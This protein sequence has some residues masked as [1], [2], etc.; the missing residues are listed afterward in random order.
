MK[1]LLII[2]ALASCIIIVFCAMGRLAS[3]DN[4]STPLVYLYLK[5]TLNTHMYTYI[6]RFIKNLRKERFM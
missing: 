1:T 4:C 5:T 6:H 3:A 2:S